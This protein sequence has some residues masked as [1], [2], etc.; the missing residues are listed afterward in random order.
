MWPAGAYRVDAPAAP[1]TYLDHRT[2][3]EVVGRALVHNLALVHGFVK[4]CADVA[5]L[6]GLR[7]EQQ[8]A[9]DQAAPTLAAVGST[10]YAWYRFSEAADDGLSIVTPNDTQG[11][12]GRW[13]KQVLPE[14]A[15]C[16]RARYYLHIEMCDNRLTTKQLWARCNG[17]TPALF[18]SFVGS[19]PQEASQTRAFYNF[20]LQYRLRVISANWRG[21]VQARFTSA[22]K[23]TQ[24]QPESQSDPGASRLIGDLRHYFVEDNR[25]SQPL[26]GINHVLLGRHV[27]LDSM[28][29]EG[30]L[31]DALN[32]TVHAA[33][34]TPNESCQYVDPAHLWLQLQDALGRGAGPN[35]QLGAPT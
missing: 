28:D 33:V 31:V 22:A 24:G 29:R 9:N 8:D 6:R 35:N 5:E 7:G 21:G 13:I 4:Q 17:Q 10:I 25:L 30:V 3:D 19:E 26:L 14:P 20:N 15:R 11:N 12:P 18:I 1:G 2:A 32:I 16:G 34:W 23:D 27:P